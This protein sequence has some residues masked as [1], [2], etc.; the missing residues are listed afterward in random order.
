VL[1]DALLGVYSSAGITI[2]GTTRKH[3]YKFQLPAEEEGGE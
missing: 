1:R 3:I 2:E